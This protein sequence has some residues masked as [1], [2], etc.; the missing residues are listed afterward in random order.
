MDD[1]I[2]F[3]DDIERYQEDDGFD[4][5]VQTTI[6]PGDT[7]FIITAAFCAVSILALPFLVGLGNRRAAKRKARRGIQLE[8]DGNTATIINIEKI[9][10]SNVSESETA[11]DINA[12]DDAD[13]S[14][15][16]ED[17]DLSIFSQIEK[18]YLS[19]DAI[20]GDD[21]DSFCCGERNDV[22]SDILQTPFCCVGPDMNAMELPPISP[23]R[24]N[25]KRTHEGAF[26]NPDSSSNPGRLSPFLKRNTSNSSI[27]SMGNRKKINRR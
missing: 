16:A 10:E 18:E 8:S 17:D 14:S 15:N 23:K 22:M 19:S 2:E 20:Q 4:N 3:N 9:D 26:S 6:D 1:Y 27:D 13:E 24:K 7:L 21:S 25:K 12:A 11:N 5:Y